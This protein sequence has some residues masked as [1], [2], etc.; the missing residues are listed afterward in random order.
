MQYATGER[1]HDSAT[2]ALNQQVAHSR[3]LQSF[4]HPVDQTKSLSRLCYTDTILIFALLDV[5]HFHIYSIRHTGNFVS[6]TIKNR[7]KDSDRGGPY[8]PLLSCYRIGLYKY[9]INVYIYL[10]II[11]IMRRCAHLC[12]DIISQGVSFHMKKYIKSKTK[13]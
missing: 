10:F 2:S 7:R 1:C 13:M 11:F 3:A 9:V 12:V 6:V 8:S 5:H 4:V